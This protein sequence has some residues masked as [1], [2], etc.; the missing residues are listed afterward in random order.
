MTTRAD[1]DLLADATRTLADLA[2]AD[3]ERLVSSLDLSNPER[4]R[5]AL[6]E[7]VPALTGRYGQAAASV[8]ADW[9]DDLREQAGA[10]GRFTAQAAETVPEEVV[11]KGVR[12]EARHLWTDTPSLIVPALA[13]VVSKHVAQPARDTV[14]HNA[15]RD[16]AKPSW[17][18]VPR[19]AKTCAW[20]MALASRGPVYDSQLAAVQRRHGGTYHGD[21]DCHPALIY[22]GQGL[23]EGY[24]P[25]ANYA[26]YAL[27]RDVAGSGDLRDITA[28]M[29]RMFPADLTD[30]VLDAAA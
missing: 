26:R 3:M 18:R 1:V 4:V 24:D 17:A 15:T 25:A 14:A 5:D 29:R 9:Y 21:C 11:I 12:Y 10:A 6:V 20:C 27:A 23:P 7:Y 30:G 8:A 28:A 16:P 2:K 19:G 22:P 13:L